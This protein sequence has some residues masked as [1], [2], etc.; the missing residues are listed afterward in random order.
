MNEK[1]KEDKHFQKYYARLR[2]EALLK[3]LLFGGLIAFCISFAFAAVSWFIFPVGFFIAL[4]ILLPGTVGL[5]ALIY[6]T[7]YRPNT[8]SNAR[9]LDRLGL[10]E[11]LVTM[12]EYRN[13]DSYMAEIQRNDARATLEKVH[14]NDIRLA[15]SKKLLIPASVMLTLAFA[16]T[17]ING[18]SYFGVIPTGQELL[19]QATQSEE[20]KYVQVQYKIKNNDAGYIIGETKQYM[21]KGSDA[22]LVVAIANEGYTFEAWSD[23]TLTP[24]RIDKEIL[25]N[26]DVYAIFSEIDKPFLDD[27]GDGDEPDDLPPEGGN[28]SS[29][30][31]DSSSSGPS[32]YKTYN[33]FID[34]ETYYRELLELYRDDI[35]AY[36]NTHGAEMTPEER[37]IIEAYIGI[38]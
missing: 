27:D 24:A 20:S 7:K 22:K 30:S 10:E 31:N 25:E 37:E 3:S 18:L 36:L 14:V 35:I 6:F 33:Q 19:I 28:D 34:G 8:M 29:N 38:V 23:G 26:I 5:T 16:M 9:R 11:R 21:L 32:K 12:I 15:L 13:D 17:V 2:L 1:L 4:A